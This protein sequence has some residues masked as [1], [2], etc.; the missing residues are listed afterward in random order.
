MPVVAAADGRITS[1]RD[2]GIGGKVVFLHPAGKDYTLYYAH[3]DSQLV[4]E[5]QPVKTGEVVG[6]MG[7]T[8]NAKYTTPHL[9]FGIYASGGAVDPLPFVKAVTVQPAAITVPFTVP[10][11]FVRS[12]KATTV[13]STM[14]RDKPAQKIKAGT[15]LRVVGATS[16]WYR[17][18]L[19]DGETALVAGS[20]VTK[21]DKPVDKHRVELKQLLLDAP[22]ASA[23]AKSSIEEGTTIDVYGSSGDYLFVE[24]KGLNGWIQK[25]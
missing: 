16:G 9:H 14:Q 19:P 3:L 20:D 2:G 5:G 6:L 10:G 25:L 11:K 7:N 4:S 22:A 24:Y 15:P 18:E 23:T 21:A 17:V 12:T 8:G 13:V 1:V